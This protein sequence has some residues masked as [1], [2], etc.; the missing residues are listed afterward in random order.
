MHQDRT[1]DSG[2]SSKLAKYGRFGDDSIAHVQQGELIVPH[3]IQTPQVM[4]A[5]KQEFNRNNVPM[6]RYIVGSEKNSE[7]PDTG[8][9]EYFLSALAS[10]AL[11]TVVSFAAD[12]IMGGGD[13][14]AG[15]PNPQDATSPPNANRLPEPVQATNERPDPKRFL[16]GV[17]FIPLQDDAVQSKEPVVMGQPSSLIP[18]GGNSMNPITNKPEYY[19]FSSYGAPKGSMKDNPGMD[20]RS[21]NSKNPKTGMSEFYDPITPSGLTRSANQEAKRKAGYTGGFSDPNEFQNWA[22]TNLGGYLKYIDYADD[23]PNFTNPVDLDVN[24]A[25]QQTFSRD[26]NRYLGSQVGWSGEVG[27]GQLGSGIKDVDY[28]TLNPQYQEKYSNL[29]SLAQPGYQYGTRTELPGDFNE[30][31]YMANNPNVAAKVAGGNKYTSGAH[32]YYLEGKDQGLDYSKQATPSW[33]SSLMDRL[34]KY[35]NQSSGGS[36]QDDFGAQASDQ[37][38]STGSSLQNVNA[39]S[40]PVKAPQL[41]SQRFAGSYA[42]SF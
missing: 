23:N 41:R 39:P 18:S 38:S 5:V 6:E 42:S 2:P 31:Q 20:Y 16:H 29:R 14:G 35:D 17:G 1:V 22:R 27:Q 32:H 12:K 24:K 15:T 36:Q 30:S 28:L 26:L 8:K 25:G 19:D 21:K 9:G 33:Y 37:G 3:S 13:S 7:N 34:D 40:T 4:N 10:A 11:P